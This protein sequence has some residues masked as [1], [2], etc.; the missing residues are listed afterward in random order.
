MQLIVTLESSED[1]YTLDV[2]SSMTLDDLRAVVEAETNVPTDRQVLFYKAAIL[3]GNERELQTFGMEDYDMIM[4]RVQQPS[5][6]P[7][8]RPNAMN[9]PDQTAVMNDV[10]KI[11]LQMLGDQALRDMV[12]HIQI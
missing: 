12:R 2:A 11:R 6:P 7:S 9:T 4:L 1:I 5:I 10:E 3:E 8:A